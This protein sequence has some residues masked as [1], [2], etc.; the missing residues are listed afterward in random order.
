M[1]QENPRRDGRMPQ[2][3]QIAILIVVTLLV[4]GIYVFR[5]ATSEPPQQEQM[6]TTGSATVDRAGE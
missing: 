6:A 3:T 2:A 4:V 5:T 1:A